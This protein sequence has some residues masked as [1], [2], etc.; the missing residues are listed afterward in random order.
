MVF[1]STGWDMAAVLTSIT[2][3][4]GNPIVVGVV[5]LSFGFVLAPKA[6]GALRQSIDDRREMNHVWGRH[7]DE[8]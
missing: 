6:I 8:D 2:D 5:M 1:P 4:L 3:F 7:E